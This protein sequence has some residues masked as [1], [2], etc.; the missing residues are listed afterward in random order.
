M[1][2]LLPGDF[3]LESGIRVAQWCAIAPE[4]AS[5]DDVLKPDFWMHVAGALKT[6]AA[7]AAHQFVDVVHKG[8]RFIGRVY[9]LGV[10][11]QGALVEEVYRREVA[12]NAREADE[13]AALD[14]QNRGGAKKWTI[15]RKADG[16]VIKDGFAT[17][18]AAR[19]WLKDQKQSLAA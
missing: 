8:H 10:T 18:H 4:E 7:V 16:E 9:V 14:L 19:A 2:K 11:P 13:P 5:F 6:Q 12:A 3:S 1:V 17:R 15:V